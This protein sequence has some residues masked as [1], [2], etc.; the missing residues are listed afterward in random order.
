MCVSQDESYGVNVPIINLQNANDNNNS[1]PSMVPPKK[2][3]Q[4]QPGNSLPTVPF[5][6]SEDTRMF[7]EKS[8]FQ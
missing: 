6:F 2:K 5:S 7:Q 3:I 1:K 4:P 8:E